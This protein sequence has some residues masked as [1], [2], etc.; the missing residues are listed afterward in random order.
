M[1]ILKDVKDR[2][3]AWAKNFEA[4]LCC[5]VNYDKK[6]LEIIPQEVIDR[7]YGCWDPSKYV[8]EGETVLDLWSG[9]G[10]ICFIAAQIVWPKW[11]VIWV[12]MTDDMLELA[13]KSKKEVV[14]KM[15]YDNIEFKHWYIQD[16]KTD[17]DEIDKILKKFSVKSSSDFKEL[18]EKI[19][20]LKKELPMIKDNSIDV[21]VSNCVLNLVSDDLKKDLFSEMFRVLK[22][23]WRIAIS[24]IVS[25]EDSPEYLKNDPN[26]WSWCLTWAL[27]EKK[28]LDELEKSWFY[29]IT[30]D[31]YDK[32]PWHVVEA[33][34]FRSVTIIAYKWKEWICKE[35][36]QAVIYKGPW[37]SVTDDDWHTF[38]RWDRMAVCEKTTNI[39]KKEPYWDSI[40]VVEPL[41]EFDKDLDFDCSWKKLF[42]SPRET[43]LWIIRENTYSDIDNP[44]SSDSCC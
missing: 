40:I 22:V 34:E 14:K 43:K 16:L 17:L 19:E 13:N 23:W 37:K 33:I 28:F 8:K 20:K 31:K 39:M 11:K 15:G 21:I 44:C 30:L 4:T 9:W 27:Q 1:S 38:Y 2:Y 29:W 25:D 10:K 24:D 42:R 36:N 3:S 7:D 35:K 26:L 41:L 18:N 6:Y 32:E 12:D 5:A